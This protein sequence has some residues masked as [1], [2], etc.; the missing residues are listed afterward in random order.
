MADE[1]GIDFLGEIPLHPDVR[2]GADIGL[3]IV[4]AAPESPVAR[5]FG[6]IA[7]KIAAKT[8]VQHFFAEATPA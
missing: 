7:Q 4:Q 1:M 3:P 5:A 6:E 2:A 8:S